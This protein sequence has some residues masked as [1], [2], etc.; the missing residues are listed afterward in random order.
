MYGIGIGMFANQ[1]LS[2]FERAV[3]NAKPKKRAV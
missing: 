1:L 2:L 3:M